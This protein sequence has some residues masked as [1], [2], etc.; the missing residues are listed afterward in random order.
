V[1]ASAQQASTPGKPEAAGEHFIETQA[2]AQP[3]GFVR[4]FADQGEAV[5]ALLAMVTRRQGQGRAAAPNSVR[6]YAVELLEACGGSRASAR[7]SHPT[8]KSQGLVE[9]LT[10]RETEVLLLLAAGD[11]N[12]VIAEKLV[13]TVR[14]V[15][16]HTGNIYGKLNVHSR[17]QAVARARLLGLLA[18]DR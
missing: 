1:E 12:R 14:A 15:K 8:P 10:A 6:T 16:K 11:S 2:F 9:A 18:D 13:I 3:E 17:T 5:Q 4:V 7:G